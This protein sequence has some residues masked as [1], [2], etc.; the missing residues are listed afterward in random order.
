MNMWTS[1]GILVKAFEETRSDVFGTL[2]A[3]KTCA[4]MTLYA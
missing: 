2:R 1:W 4:Y 3:Q